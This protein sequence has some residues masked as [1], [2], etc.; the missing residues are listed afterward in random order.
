[1]KWFLITACAI[2]L[3]VH[4]YAQQ[5]YAVS[6]IPKE[7]LPYASNVVRDN[8]ITTEVK[9]LNN[10][11]YHVKTVITVLNKNGDEDAHIV[12]F[13]DKTNVIRYVKGVVY[14]EFG[15][16]ISKFSESNFT[17]QSAINS[18]SLFEDERVKHFAPPATSY[19]YTVAYEYELRS[20]QSLN[21]R[22]WRPNSSSSTAVENSTFTFICKPDFNI[23]YKEINVPEKVNIATNATGLKTYT[24]KISNLKASRNEPYSPNPASYLT[25]VK[26]SPEKFEYGGIKGSFTNWQE[27]GK[28]YYDKLLTN[29]QYLPNETVDHIKTITADVADPKLKAKKIYEYMQGKTH[30]ISVQVG[31]GGYQP[32]LAMDVD[33]QNY[34]D[35]KAL[36]NYM[37]ALLKIVNI[38]SYFCVVEAG[39]R[40]VSM[41][42]DFASMNQA[43][44]AILCIPIKNDTTWLECTS[45]KIPFGFLGDFTDDRTVLACTPQGGKLMHTPVYTAQQNVQTRKANFVIN[46]NGALSGDMTTVFKGIQYENHEYLIDESPVEQNKI[47][48]KIY[49]INNLIVKKLDLKQDKTIQPVTT[50]NIKLEARDYATQEDGKFYFMLNPVNREGSIPTAVRNRHN[51]VYINDGFTDEDEIIYNLPA[52]YRFSKK[53]I[54]V[55]IEKPFGKYT[56]TMVLKDNQ[57]IYKRHMQMID[58]TYSK[59]LYQDLVDF[60]QEITDADHYNV[61]LSKAAN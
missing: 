54:N 43:N 56:V 9:D 51:D 1:M 31:I 53:P 8:E 58:G 39:D 17:D 21:F 22:D 49:P 13:H 26:I 3:C 45:Q 10:T 55:S 35:C 41:L 36:V 40:K 38:E 6:L 60:Y 30:Y 27:L 4:T 44:H 28:W 24:W 14:D 34:G 19:P 47:I 23:R 11:I 32:F 46:E 48:Q 29:R 33:K 37:Q 20:E 2:L 16:Q 50:E 42:P 61:M 18:F 25:S 52:G 12:I 15:K 59:D 5:N 7:L 57:L